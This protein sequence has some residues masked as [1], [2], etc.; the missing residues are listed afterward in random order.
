MKS[1]LSKHCLWASLTCTKVHEKFCILP[2]LKYNSSC[3]LSSRAQ[4]SLS[5]Y[6]RFSFF[7]RTFFLVHLFIVSDLVFYMS[8]CE[9]QH[10]LYVVGLPVFCD[11]PKAV[12]T[13]ISS[14]CWLIMDFYYVTDAI[15]L[16]SGREKKSLAWSRMVTLIVNV[17][18]PWLN[19]VSK[20]NGSLIVLAKWMG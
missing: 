14:P 15:R 10:D 13:T 6:R 2:P 19:V 16:C 8:R 7:F 20:L 5:H 17:I 3:M 4:P 11:A 1:I 9:L 12:N 18:Y